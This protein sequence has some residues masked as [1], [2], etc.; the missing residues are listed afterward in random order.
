MRYFHSKLFNRHRSS[1]RALGD[2]LKDDPIFDKYL[3]EEDD[4]E[5]VPRHR[6]TSLLSDRKA[7]QI[8]SRKG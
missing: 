2:A 1:A 6:Q 4:G 7:P 5:G 3:E 8:W